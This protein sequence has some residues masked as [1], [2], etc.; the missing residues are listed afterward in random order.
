M[1]TS[2]AVMAWLPVLQLWYDGTAATRY[3]KEE[4]AFS[5][6]R[7]RA[8]GNP[9]TSAGKHARYWNFM[10]LVTKQMIYGTKHRK[11]I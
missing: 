7:D 1:Q 5:R 8:G 4:E 11:Y 6:N 2:N 10:E 3:Y 9:V